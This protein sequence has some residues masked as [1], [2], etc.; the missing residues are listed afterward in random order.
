MSLAEEMRL[1]PFRHL[2]LDDHWNP[3]LL[4]EV[5]DEFPPETDRRWIRY[6]NEHEVKLHGD[7]PMWGDST[8]YL[9][10]EFRRLTWDLSEVFGIPNLMLET[11]GGGMHLIP[12]GGKLDVH[13]DFNRSPDTGMYRRLNLMCYLNRNWEDEGGWLEL[14]PPDEGEPVRYEPRFNRTVVFECS[15]Q[16]WHDHQV[17]AK[18][19]RLSVAGYYFSPDPPEG[20]SEDHSTIWRFP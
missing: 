12:P 5:F 2:V 13:A 19:W 16:S 8:R 1:M 17:P 3:T 14:W 9:L 7:T 18:R 15:D 10:E 4:E 20:Y 11:V 6:N